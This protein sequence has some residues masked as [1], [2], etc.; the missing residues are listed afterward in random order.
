MTPRIPKDLFEKGFIS[1]EQYEKID[2]VTSG[3][4]VS[5]FYE[6]HGLLYLGVLLFTGGIGVLVYQNIGDLG[7]LVSIGLLVVLTVGCFIYIFRKGPAYSNSEVSGP[8]LYFSYVVL[9]AS[10]LFISIQGYLQ[11]QFGILTENL[12][13][14]T[15]V[16]AFFFF[17]IAY[18]FD[19]LGVLSLA[20]TALA[21]FWSISISPQKWYS[22]EFFSGPHLYNTAIVFS[23]ALAAIA[24]FL[25]KKRIKQHFTFTYL[26]FCVLIFLTGATAGMFVDEGR[27][28]LYAL[29][30]FGG[31]AFAYF[32]ARQQQSFLFLLYAFIAGF[33]GTTYVLFMTILEHAEELW[34]Y[35]FIVSCGGFIWFIIKYKNHFTRKE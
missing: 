15:L 32:A 19:H 22:D 8:T 3:K 35:Y 18:R 9:L 33:I 34:F 14:S 29:L 13:Y 23:T 28:G 30:I 25:N 20:I 11:F 4:V 24:I 31:C 2:L 17:F 21:S 1:T 27:F 10:L 6:L 5:I 26:N 12:E 16:T 7:H